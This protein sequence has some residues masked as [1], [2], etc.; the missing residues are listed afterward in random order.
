MSDHVLMSPHG[1][2]SGDALLGRL[3][4]RSPQPQLLYR[5]DSAPGL[6]ANR[7]FLE[8]FGF[9]SAE[10]DGLSLEV[11]FPVQTGRIRSNLRK[12]GTEG[13]AAFE[14]DM[15]LPD[16]RSC[17]V[18]VQATALSDPPA[19]FHLSIQDLRP[20]DRERERAALFDTIL[21]QFPEGVFYKDIYGTYRG[22]NRAFEELAGRPMEEIQGKTDQELLP[23]EWADICVANDR[24]VLT[25]EAPH[26]DEEWI[27]NLKTGEPLLLDMVKMP[28]MGPNGEIRGLLGVARDAT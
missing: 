21:R 26:R 17:P 11:L 14:I 23:R 5:T 2:A 1:T 27:R 9:R 20:R 7:A 24:E 8:R 28:F 6:Q 18:E 3:F 16:G 13:L 12:A 19:L 10:V 4:G 15:G 25:R 22:G